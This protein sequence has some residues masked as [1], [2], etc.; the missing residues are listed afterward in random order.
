MHHTSFKW[1]MLNEEHPF[2]GYFGSKPN[3][4]ILLGG[5]PHQDLRYNSYIFFNTHSNIMIDWF[6]FL[7]LLLCVCFFL[8]LLALCLQSMWCLLLLWLSYSFLSAFVLLIYSVL[9]D[10][11]VFSLSVL[12]C[13]QGFVITLNEKVTTSWG[14]VEDHPFDAEATAYILWLKAT[15]HHITITITENWLMI[16]NNG[17]HCI[18]RAVIMLQTNNLICAL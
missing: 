16:A 11:I 17:N 18:L 6:Y 8:L 10:L 7:L 9:L 14:L 3:I 2:L 13:L 5:C 1:M 4:H 12:F 15:T